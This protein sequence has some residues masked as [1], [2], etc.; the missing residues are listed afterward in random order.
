MSASLSNLAS[1]EIPE[2]ANAVGGATSAVTDARPRA[3]VVAHLRRGIDQGLWGPGQRLPSMQALSEE[4]QVNRR[5]V[6]SAIER[7]NE[8]GIIRSNGGRMHIV[9]ADTNAS[10]GVQPSLMQHTIAVLTRNVDFPK[11]QHRQTGWVEFIAQGAVEAVRGTGLH[12]M[13]LQPQRLLQEG[14]EL[15]ASAPPRGVVLTDI[16]AMQE[17]IGELVATL[18]R[19]GIPFV[20]YGNAPDMGCDLVLSD[21][22]EGSYQLTKWLLARGRHRIV[23][24]RPQATQGYWFPLRRQGYEQAMREAGLEPLP[25]VEVP[26]EVPHESTIQEDDFDY[27]A[28]C[29][30]GFLIEALSGDEACDALLTASDG[31]MFPLARA[32]RLLGREPNRDVDIVG[33]D[34]YWRDVHMRRFEAFEP[35]A[36]VD[37]NNQQM[38]RE[39]VQLLSDRIAGNLPPEPQRRVVAPRLVVTQSD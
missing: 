10:G 27:T 39:L 37:K 7:L 18:R 17:E 15:L 29:C 38:G 33:Y 9:T 19:S 8:E 4:L 16:Y 13:L 26:R 32:C 5:T 11:S 24:T 12:A 20:A 31:Y 28:R 30:V 3:R 6:R 14:M 22:R 25:D 35:L 36:T 2:E 21:H 1:R 23:N 34:N